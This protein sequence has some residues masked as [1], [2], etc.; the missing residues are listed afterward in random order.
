MFQVIGENFLVVVMGAML[1]FAAVLAYVSIT[2]RDPA[3][4]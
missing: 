1:A 4:R 2:D 3:G